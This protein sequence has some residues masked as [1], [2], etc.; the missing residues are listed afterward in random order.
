MLKAG[1]RFGCLCLL[2]VYQSFS[3]VIF[4]LS[5]CIGIPSQC[6]YPISCSEFAKIQLEQEASLPRATKRIVLRLLSCN[7]WSSFFY[8]PLPESLMRQESSKGK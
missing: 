1:L 6:R 7:P 4:F 5:H 8:S 2:F 3:R